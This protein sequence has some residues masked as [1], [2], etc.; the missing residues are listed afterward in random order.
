MCEQKF[1]T[2]YKH[3]NYFWDV[4]Y[5]FLNTK[6]IFPKLNY[7][8]KNKFFQNLYKYKNKFITLN[9]STMCMDR[10]QYS[11]KWYELI[12]E[13][14]HSW[15]QKHIPLK[16]KWVKPKFLILKNNIKLMCVCALEPSSVI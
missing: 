7:K 16:S 3:V 4:K 8:L 2:Y 11:V 10:I 1:N 14:I 9:L 6:I 13:K 12:F 15:N 5:F